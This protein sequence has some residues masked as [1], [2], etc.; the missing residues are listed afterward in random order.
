MALACCGCADLYTTQ[1]VRAD[2]NIQAQQVQAYAQ[3]QQA[4]ITKLNT[5]YTNTYNR[6]TKQ[7]VDLETQQLTQD[8]TLDA[9][10]SA[11]KLIFDPNALLQGQFRDATQTT[12][13]NELADINN[14]DT[15]IANARNAYADAYSQVSLDIS[16]LKTV[17]SNLAT[18]AE[19]EKESR[20]IEALV[21][22]IYKAYQAVQK[23]EKQ[24]AQPAK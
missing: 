7:L 15:A 11:D 12:I 5:D 8:F 3:Q 14:V 6:L 20:D 18:L 4:R 17:Q 24:A 22:K 23:Q 10:R 21:T 2:A 1:T 9:V 13:S 19:D 16:K